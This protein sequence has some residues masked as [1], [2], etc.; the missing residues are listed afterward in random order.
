MKNAKTAVIACLSAFCTI[1]AAAQDKPHSLL[2]DLLE[3]TDKTWGGGIEISGAAQ[4]VTNVQYAEI[5][6]A[7]PSFSWIVPGDGTPAMQTAYR[8]IL[9]DNR[10]DAENGKG[11]I[12]DSGTVNS[13]RIGIRDLMRARPS[14]RIRNISGG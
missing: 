1:L 13:E 7:H 2:T 9:S 12:W 10:E 8:I 6:S 14:S 11:N 4:G 5:A 3:H